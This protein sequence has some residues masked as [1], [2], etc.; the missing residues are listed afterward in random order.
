LNNFSFQSLSTI[1]Q[2]ASEAATEIPLDEDEMLPDIGKM[3][4][5]NIHGFIS[6]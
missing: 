5:E 3:G 1:E 4:G 2:S 6:N